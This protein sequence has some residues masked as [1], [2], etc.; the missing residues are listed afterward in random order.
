MNE[1]TIEV[2]KFDKRTKSGD[3]LIQATD[4]VVQSPKS[5]VALHWAAVYPAPTYRT[6]VHDTW[7][8]KKNLM[9]GK[10]FQERYDTPY[11]MS[12]SSETYWA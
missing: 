9:T 5:A 4:T 8:T 12:M 7:V 10:E 6:E 1:Y 11:Y 3:R 2:Y